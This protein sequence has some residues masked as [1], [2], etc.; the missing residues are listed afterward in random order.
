VVGCG[1]LATGAHLPNIRQS[2]L[3]E[4]VV[5][6]DSRQEAA[7]AAKARFGAAR[8]AADWREVV[9]APDVELIVLCTHTGLRGELICEALRRGKPVYTE[10]PLAKSRREMMEILR[11][12][13]A[14]GVSVCVGHNRRSSPAVLE[15]KRL[16]DK[17]RREGAGRRPSV[18]RSVEGCKPL[19]EER[20]MQLLIRVN[21]DI[22]SWKG[23]IFD[24]EEGIL[25]TEMVHFIDLA[26]WLNPTPPIEV[27]ACGSPRGNFTEVIRFQ[28][29]S[30]AT[31]HHSMVGHFDYPKE[32]FEAS[33]RNV[34]I[35]MDHHVE[36]RQRG[37]ADEPFRRN[38]AIG[39][40]ET[41]AEGIEAFHGQVDAAQAAM[42]HFAGLGYVCA[43]T[44]YRF[45]PAHRF[46]AQFEDVRLGFS[47]FRSRAGEYGFDARRTAS[48][49][50][51]A[52]AHLAALLAVV[53]PD[54][55]LGATDGLPVRDTVPA[56]VVCLCGVLTAF[57]HTEHD[58]IPEMLADFLGTDESRDPELVRRASPLE[59]VRGGEPPFL[60]IV[61]DADRTTPVALHERMRDRLAACGGTG[62]LH[63]LPG[64]DHGFGT[65]FPLRPNSAHSSWRPISCGGGCEGDDEGKTVGMLKPD[66]CYVWVVAPSVTAH[67]GP[68]DQ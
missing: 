27:Y 16:I 23:W 30:L 1:A 66:G 59:R 52:G 36:I 10:K 38:F 8:A 48:W 62:E 32:L 3:F 53:S 24:D 26:L 17:A 42:D 33:L 18:D 61:G 46:P 39:V 9:A 2:D 47:W 14:T 54:D 37:L 44:S 28:D 60:M 21:D 4:L 6:C 41:G 51:S 25:V 40:E 35:A 15:F 58:N 5:A 12:S 67:G 63:V 55:P 56:A 19:A 68:M 29:S 43:S 64:V 50:S 11:A 7:E 22:R 34:T 20:Q 31:L 65:G 13:D 57:R 49:G 45:A